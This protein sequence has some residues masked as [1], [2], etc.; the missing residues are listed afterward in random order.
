[1]IQ[2]LTEEQALESEK[3]MDNFLLSLDF[4]T[5]SE[6]V[7][8]LKPLIEKI[9][10]EHDFIDTDSYE[11]ELPKNMYL[12]RKCNFMKEKTYQFEKEYQSDE[13]A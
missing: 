3:K 4:N 11:N 9:N 12:C 1:M 6:I 7:R 2:I 5:K 13:L 8:L 10:C